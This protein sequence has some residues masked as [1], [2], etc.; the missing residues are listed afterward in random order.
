[1]IRQEKRTIGS[2]G[3]KS[4]FNKMIFGPPRQQKRAKR[5]CA[6]AKNAAADCL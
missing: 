2:D 6:T 1:M 4:N 5:D 3:R